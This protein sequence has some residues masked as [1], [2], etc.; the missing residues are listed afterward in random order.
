[1]IFPCTTPGMVLWVGLY[2]RSIVDRP[3]TREDLKLGIRIFP[4]EVTDCRCM[5]CRY[6]RIFGIK[7]IM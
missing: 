5:F 6:Y 3:T 4:D 2:M 7:V 1:M